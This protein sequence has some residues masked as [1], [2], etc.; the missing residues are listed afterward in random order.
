[1][2]TYAFGAAV[3]KEDERIKA[4]YETVPSPNGTGM[5]WLSGPAVRRPDEAGAGE[6]AWNRRHPSESWTESAHGRRCTAL[7]PGEFHG[8]CA[9]RAFVSR[10]L[11][12]GRLCQARTARRMQDFATSAQW[13]KS[14]PHSTRKID[15]TGFCFGGGRPIPWRFCW[16]RFWRPPV[17]RWRARAGRRAEKN[18]GGHPHPPR[19]PRQGVVG[20]LS[21]AG[22]SAEHPVRRPHL[23]EFASRVLQQRGRRTPQRALRS[24]TSI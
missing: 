5:S 24:R 12:S 22:S 13:L 8:L 18:Q 19:R 3:R 4:S 9:R 15:T 14:R 20:S 10:R 7:R 2:P 6:T 11:L 16:A 21:R 1:M 17:L 23:F